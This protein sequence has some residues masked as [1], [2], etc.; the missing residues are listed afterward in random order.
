VP[1]ALLTGLLI[2][3]CGRRPVMIAAAL[4]QIPGIAVLI[5]P[6]QGAT[7]ELA[8]A[9]AVGLFFLLYN[10]VVAVITTL[11]MDHAS[12]KSP[13]T[14]Y[15][16]QYSLYMLFSILAVSAGTA[17]A[18]QVGYLPVLGA[19]AASALAMALLSLSWRF[20]PSPETAADPTS[21]SQV[22]TAPVS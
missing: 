3:R 20:Q 22:C 8:V 16:S 1:A 14:D 5:L 12:P 7:G 17:L 6:V 11:M 15:A 13:A 9:L 2:R 19:A 4:L 21:E 10:P 18:G